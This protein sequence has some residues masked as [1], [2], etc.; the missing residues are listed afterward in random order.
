MP[1]SL[2]RSERLLLSLLALAVV[3][4]LTGLLIF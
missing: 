4:G 3:L 1:F 2:T